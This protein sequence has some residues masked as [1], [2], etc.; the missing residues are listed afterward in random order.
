MSSR[1]GWIIVA[2]NLKPREDE[3]AGELRPDKTPMQKRREKASNHIMWKV[4][5]D[6]ELCF[7]YGKEFTLIQGQF[8][9]GLSPPEQI[10]EFCRRHS[11]GSMALWLAVEGTSGSC[12]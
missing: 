1:F 4:D 3:L 9:M 6:L 11:K 8:D 7:G 10:D 12:F 2:N 5:D